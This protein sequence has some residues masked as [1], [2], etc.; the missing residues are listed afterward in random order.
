[1]NN[2]TSNLENNESNNNIIRLNSID[3]FKIIN[4]N[5]EEN[6]IN[7]NEQ[8][9]NINIS[10]SNVQNININ[11][12]PEKVYNLLLDEIYETISDNKELFENKNINISK[13]EVKYENRKT[14]WLNYDKNCQQINRDTRQ[15][16]K[17][18]D[19]ELGV[20]TSINEKLQLIFR[21]RYD[22][23]V[24]AKHYKKYIKEF[25]Q[26]SSCCKFDTEIIRS[27]RLDFLKC[28]KSGC[29]T[30]KVINKL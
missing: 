16:K 8:S 27:N 23:A 29:N 26:C 25:V 13:P 15:L 4:P 6:E 5:L 20:E 18:I 22:F 11:M 7:E 21:G 19:K 17:F 3:S 12:E 24:I 1:M 9:T 28:L 14:F 10:I 30:C 2:I